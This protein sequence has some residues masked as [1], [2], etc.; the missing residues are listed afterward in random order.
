MDKLI[1]IYQK[2]IEKKLLMLKNILFQ[3]KQEFLIE[4]YYK[5][6]SKYKITVR[7]IY[8]TTGYRECIPSKIKNV[9]NTYLGKL[10]NLFRDLES[11][12]IK[13]L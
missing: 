3:R 12:Y 8:K 11:I 5:L 1:I 9:K 13:T 7:I 2:N 4:Y 10:K 6:V